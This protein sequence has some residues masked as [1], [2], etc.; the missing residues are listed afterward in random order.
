MVK[1]VVLVFFSLGPLLIVGYCNYA[2]N[3]DPFMYNP[4]RSKRP[5]YS[6]AL[7]LASDLRGVVGYSAAS[8]VLKKKGWEINRKQFYNL[9]CM[10][11]KGTLTRQDELVLL[12][13]VLD[14]EVRKVKNYNQ[15]FEQIVVQ[16]S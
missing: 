8:Q 15:L 11:E 2:P 14:N 13:K 6:E 1:L 10:E 7:K 3:P 5:G 16:P 4:Y 12:L 9:F